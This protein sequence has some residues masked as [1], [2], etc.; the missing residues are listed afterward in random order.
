MGGVGFIKAN[1]FESFGFRKPAATLLVF[2][3]R[4]VA[5]FDW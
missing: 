2:D 1:F 3:W 5:D 4:E